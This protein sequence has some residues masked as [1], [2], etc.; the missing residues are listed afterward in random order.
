MEAMPRDLVRYC[1]SKQKCGVNRTD[2]VIQL[3]NVVGVIFRAAYCPD[4]LLMRTP[5]SKFLLFRSVSGS[6]EC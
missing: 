1:Y 6:Y 2:C 3:Q 5:P 4:Q